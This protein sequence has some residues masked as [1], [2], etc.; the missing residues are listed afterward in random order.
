MRPS[1]EGLVCTVTPFQLILKNFKRRQHFFNPGASFECFDAHSSMGPKEK[2]SLRIPE[3]CRFE[4]GCFGDS[5]ISMLDLLARNC[6]VEE[7]K[8]WLVN[9]SFY[10]CETAHA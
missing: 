4:Q 8:C 6:R 5:T 9:E 2:R 7:K 1:I 10:A 3:R